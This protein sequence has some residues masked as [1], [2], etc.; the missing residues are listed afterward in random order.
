MYIVKRW[1]TMMERGYEVVYF[2]VLLFRNGLRITG[3][4]KG[5]FFMSEKLNLS[6]VLLRWFYHFWNIGSWNNGRYLNGRYP[7]VLAIKPIPYTVPQ[8]KGGGGEGRGHCFSGMAK[9]S[10]SSSWIP[11]LNAFV[12]R[13]GNGTLLLSL[14]F[15]TALNVD[16]VGLAL[17]LVPIMDFIFFA[18]LPVTLRLSSPSIFLTAPAR[19]FS[20]C[21]NDNISSHFKKKKKEEDKWQ[22]NL[23]FPQMNNMSTLQPSLNLHTIL[24]KSVFDRLPPG[25]ILNAFSIDVTY[26]TIRSEGMR[27]NM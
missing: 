6:Y 27:G 7:L 8:P 11:Y 3:G 24:D 15:L 23:P 14:N 12:R 9:C 10:S 4:R 5:K 13:S 20:R 22:I 21:H 26:L 18:V 16:L 19:R 25:R 2:I 17:A 1:I